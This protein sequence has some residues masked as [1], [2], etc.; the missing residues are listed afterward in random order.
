[1]TLRINQNHKRTLGCI[2][3]FLSFQDKATLTLHPNF[4]ETKEHKG[5]TTNGLAEEQNNNQTEVCQEIYN[6]HISKTH[7]TPHPKSLDKRTPPSCKYSESERYNRWNS[8]NLNKLIL[9][10][11]TIMLLPKIT[12]MKFQQYI[13][14][15]TYFSK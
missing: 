14:Y 10:Q 2:H 9:W 4:S 1:M 8:V 11:N 15:N 6:Q 5:S 13:F 7:R 12:I 3:H